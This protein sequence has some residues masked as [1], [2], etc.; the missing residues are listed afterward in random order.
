MDKAGREIM[1]NKISNPNRQSLINNPRRGFTIIELLIGMSVMLVIILAAFAVYK[2]GNKAFVDQ[3][4]FSS[5]QHDVRS[6]MFFVLRDI[7]S[8][9]AGLAQQFAAY[10]LQGVNNDPN[11]S[12]SSIQTDRLTILGN[13]DP[14]GL[15]IQGYAP[16]SGTIT[17][18]PDEFDLYP[19]TA[20]AYP[21]DPT[22]Y[23]NR[24]ILILPNPGLN[25]QIGE[26]GQITGV[27]TGSGQITFNRIN[28]SLPNGL[29][30]PN[31]ADAPSYDGGT[32]HFI[33]LKIFWLDVSGNYPGLT[34]RENSYLGQ[35]GVMYLSQWN[36]TNDDFDQLPL[37]LNIEDLQFQYHGDLNGDEQLDDNNSDGEINNLDFINWGDNYDWTDPAVVAGIRCVRIL[38][39]GKTEN[40][41]ISISG[42]PPDQ[43]RSIYGRPQ[44]ADSAE[45]AQTDNHRRFLLESTVNIRSMSLTIYNTGN[46]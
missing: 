19:Y 46:R 33:E 21:A 14:L 45:G 31:A 18:R 35:P 30:L 6:A 15:V 38:I 7:K 44:V 13:S 40:P 17:L 20:N 1:E 2:G 43:L 36:P 25:N 12:G 27:D 26:L 42:T 3:Q 34:A 8:T 23:I 28:V 16:G 22:G 11:Q 39:L 32:V 24:L 4:Q 29:A 5:L 9:G 41:F 37:A 10:F